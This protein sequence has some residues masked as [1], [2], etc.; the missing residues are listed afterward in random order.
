MKTNTMLFSAMLLSAMIT[1]QT[2]RSQETK[3]PWPGVTAKVLTENDV[4][5]ISEVTFAAGAVA[6]WHEHP[7]YT[8]Y[9]I[10]DVKMKEE[11][12]GKEPIVVEMK[13]GQAGFNTAV[14]HKTTNIGT[15]PFTAIVTELKLPQHQH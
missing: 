5:K 10:T 13:A 7:D 3:T 14:S 4:V 11:V 1:V 8:I 9:A 15:K 6:D 2:A 12:K